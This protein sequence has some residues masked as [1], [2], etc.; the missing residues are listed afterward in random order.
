MSRLSDDKKQD[1]KKQQ[2]VID[3]DV[4][5]ALLAATTP[6]APPA[7]LR[8]QVLARIQTP[9][10]PVEFK[11]LRYDAD[12]EVLQ[13]GLSFK[14][15]IVDEIAGTKSFLLR[16]LPGSK[17]TGHGHHGA[18]E[19]IVL[20]GEFLMGELTLRTGDFHLATVGS[21]HPVAYTSTGVTLYIRASIEDYPGI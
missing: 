19:C 5:N 4:L 2:D 14:R 6:I 8:A 17:M 1:D 18:E 9:Q 20:S 3:H 16:A 7:T 10:R 11:T 12:W 15:L 21:I 13:P